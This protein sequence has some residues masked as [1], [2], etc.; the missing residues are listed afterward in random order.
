[1]FQKIEMVGDAGRLH[2][3]RLRDFADGEVLLL[4]HF[5]DAAPGGIAEGFKEEVQC[6]YN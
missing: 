2:G 6:L 1:M 4:E 3:E 5:E